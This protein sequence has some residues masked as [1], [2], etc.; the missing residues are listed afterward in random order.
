MPVIIQWNYTDGTTEI[1]RI[2]AYIWRKDELKFTKTFAKIK[3][4]KSIIIDP[5]KETADIDESNNSWP[6][7]IAESRFDIYKTKKIGRGE[8]T[9]LNM[10]QK[11]RGEK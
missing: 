7:T 10:M 6:K 4:V 8:N 2:S 5:F 3:E 9:D 11:A 1:D